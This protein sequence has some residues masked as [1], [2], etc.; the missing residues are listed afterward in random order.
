MGGT[1]ALPF[2]LK[3]IEVNETKDLVVFIHDIE[4]PDIRVPHLTKG[5]AGRA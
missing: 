3:Q 2:A 5:N 4:F 1:A